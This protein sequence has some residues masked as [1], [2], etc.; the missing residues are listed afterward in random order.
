MNPQ[1]LQTLGQ[2][3]SRLLLNI[4]RESILDDSLMGIVNVKPIE[5]RDPLK[6]PITIRFKGEPGIDEGGVRKEYF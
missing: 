2:N 5:G 4:S 3:A 1:I 6:L